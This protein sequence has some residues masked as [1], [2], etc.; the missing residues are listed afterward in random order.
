MDLRARRETTIIETRWKRS[1][2][3]RDTWNV[4]L[5]SSCL[6]LLIEN[7]K[8]TP[9]P[10]VDKLHTNHLSRR[11]I[12]RDRHA[13]GRRVGME[14][15]RTFSIGVFGG[16]GAWQWT[17]KPETRRLVGAHEVKEHAGDL[18]ASR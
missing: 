11:Q 8:E 2:V 1:P 12:E 6:S 3:R 18:H 13:I 7:P 9:S 10:C 16:Y 14:E 17:Q 5:V 4:D 15:E